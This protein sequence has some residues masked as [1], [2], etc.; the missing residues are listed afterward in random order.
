MHVDGTAIPA[1]RGTAAVGAEA[2]I[3]VLV[4][5]E[6]PWI[7]D[8]LAP[9]MLH[10]PGRVECRPCSVDAAALARACVGAPD[11]GV[12][13]A[14]PGAEAAAPLVEAVV[15]LCPGLPDRVPLVALAAVVDAVDARRA[16]E[17]GA[18]GYV[19]MSDGVAAVGEAIRAAVAGSTYVGPSAGVALAR[20]AL[21]GAGADLGDREQDVLRL[22][23]LGCT[24]AEASRELRYSVRTIESVRAAVCRRLG[25]ASRRDIVAFAL[26]HGLIGGHHP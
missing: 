5:S 24:N 6:A 14:H 18:C 17:L 15:G 22:L 8:E 26:D 9:A 20:D 1:G 23:A 16:F 12:L 19:G 2:A 25:L 11:A 21:A 10:A 4:V 3:R 7:R 13:I